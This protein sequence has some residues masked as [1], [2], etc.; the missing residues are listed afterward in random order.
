M[1]LEMALFLF[2]AGL[3]VYLWAL[4]SVVAIVTSAIAADAPTIDQHQLAEWKIEAGLTE[5]HKKVAEMHT[6]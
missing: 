6:R 3:L 5:E 4:N 2:V 1:L